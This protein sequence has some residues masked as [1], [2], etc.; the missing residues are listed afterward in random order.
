MSIEDDFAGE[1][2]TTVTQPSPGPGRPRIE[3]RCPVSLLDRF[4]RSTP[5]GAW[6]LPGDDPAWETLPRVAH[7]DRLASEDPV[8]AQQR[9]IEAFGQE[10]VAWEQRVRATDWG[11]DPNWWRPAAHLDPSASYY[12]PV[13]KAV[14]SPHRELMEKYGT[15][16]LVQY[17]TWQGMPPSVLQL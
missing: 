7:D 9:A 5:T 8:R 6:F 12:D 17:A 10:Q 3:R 1:H 4:W 14:R 15:T 16:S 2:W 13:R 11:S